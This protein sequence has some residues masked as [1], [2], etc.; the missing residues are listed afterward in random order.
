MHEQPQKRKLI[1]IPGNTFLA[2]SIKAATKGISLKKYIEN[3][4]IQ[5]A[6]NPA[7]KQQI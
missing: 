3:L 4:L 5:D 6:L 1:D 7:T 2:L